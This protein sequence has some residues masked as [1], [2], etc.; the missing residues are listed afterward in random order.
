MTANDNAVPP[1][2]WLVATNN[3]KDEWVKKA[4]NILEQQ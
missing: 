1:I 3:N 4:K 2:E